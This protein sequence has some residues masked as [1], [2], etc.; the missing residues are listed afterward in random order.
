[1]TRFWPNGIG[2]ALGDS[3]AVA[4]PLQASGKIWYVSSVSG[5]DANQGNDR[6][7]PLATLGAAITASASDDII[8]LLQDHTETLVAGLTLSK[9][10]AIIGEG[11]SAGQP[12][13]S[14]KLNAAGANLFAVSTTNVEIRNIKFL[15]SAS[16]L[17]VTHIQVASTLCRIIG[18]RFEQ[19]RASIDS[20]AITLAT[21]GNQ[22][23]I[24]NCTFVSNATTAATAPGSALISGAAITD[25]E[26]QGCVF[27][28]GAHGYSSAGALTFAAGAIT[29]LKA[30]GISLLNG[31]EAFINAATTGWFNVQ[32]A[33]GGSRVE[34]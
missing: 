34:W 32:A 23:L 31:A 1:M 11:D 16:G 10:L 17:G 2:A 30:E 24:K 12:T 22:A 4:R 14:F 26:M 13:V 5:S 25:L 20:T 3:L 19:A 9:R 15:A 29:R 7:Q 8:V 33:T 27:D 28:A 18:C 21:G 6:D